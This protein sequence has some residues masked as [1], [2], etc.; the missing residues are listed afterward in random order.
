M[1]NQALEKFHFYYEQTKY[2][3]V[4]RK[5][6]C[7]SYSSIDDCDKSEITHTTFISLLTPMA[8]WRQY[9]Q[10]EIYFGTIYIT[11]HTL[12]RE[13]ITNF[14]VY[15]D[16]F[17]ISFQLSLNNFIEHGIVVKKKSLYY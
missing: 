9:R 12:P 2:E 7:S 13:T 1:K 15:N 16:N 6:E 8:S 3:I 11:S 14:Q 17:Y 5:P 4:T 10:I